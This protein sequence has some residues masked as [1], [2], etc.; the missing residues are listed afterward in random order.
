MLFNKR[1]E[2]KEEDAIYPNNVSVFPL[3]IPLLAGPAAI[4]SVVV[5]VS[6]IGG[7]YINQII[8]ISSLLLVMVIT[9][10]AFFIVSRFE[11]IVNEKLISV[12]SSIIAIILAGLSVQYV[13]DGI[14]EF[15]V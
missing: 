7:N 6:N 4:I 8:G 13:L 1:R 11:K 10:V 5:S 3:A 14:N 15:L 12:F 2:L 9:F